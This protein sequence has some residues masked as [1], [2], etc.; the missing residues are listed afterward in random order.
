M[1]LYI[2]QPFAAEQWRDASSVKRCNCQSDL[3]ATP[4]WHFAD[5]TT[6][7]PRCQYRLDGRDYSLNGGAL[8]GRNGRTWRFTAGSAPTA[9]AQVACNVPN[10]GLVP[11]FSHSSRSCGT[12]PLMVKLTVNANG[13]ACGSDIPM[14]PYLG[15][16][17]RTGH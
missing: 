6:V 8:P 5:C 13:N 17:M 10:T 15:K 11:T 4:C 2:L 12:T 16:K 1:Y 9:E 7:V 3:P 14:D